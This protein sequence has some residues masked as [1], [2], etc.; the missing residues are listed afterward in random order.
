MRLLKCKNNE[1]KYSYSTDFGEIWVS[2]TRL[3]DK[4]Y[5]VLAAVNIKTGTFD[6]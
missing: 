3:E 4:R 6:M 5:K 2:L 1:R